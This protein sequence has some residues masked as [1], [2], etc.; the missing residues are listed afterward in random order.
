MPQ[1]L[2]DM[3]GQR[4]ERLVV[5]KRA[6]IEKG[7]KPKWICQC[8]CG[9]ITIV[10][11]KHLLDGSTKSCGCY[12]KDWSREH[13]TK[14]GFGRTRLHRIWSGM[15]DRTCNP[16]SKYWKNYGGR[17]ITLCPEWYKFENF[18][19][20]AIPSG[21]QDHLTLD[22]ID[23][24]KGYSPDNCRWATIKEQENNRRN[25]VYCFYDGEKVP[26]TIL[27]ERL[28]IGVSKCRRLYG[29]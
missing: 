24:D 3:T 10:T 2:I 16:N 4:F 8:D 27:S 25:T 7:K 23:N 12:R 5:L 29:G 6:P 26:L 18:L 17:G 13:N 11:R 9:N 22:R 21:Y 14:H 20:W 1:K 15:K 19:K 28:G